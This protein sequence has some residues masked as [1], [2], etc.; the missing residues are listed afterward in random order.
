VAKQ[1]AISIL[2]IAA[3]QLFFGRPRNAL[4]QIIHVHDWYNFDCGIQF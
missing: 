4:A 2:A 1:L 3:A